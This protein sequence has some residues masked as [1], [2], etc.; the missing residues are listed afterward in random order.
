MQATATVPVG[1]A[2]RVLDDEGDSQVP[3]SEPE[4]YVTRRQLAAMMCLSVRTID[5]MVE[6]GIPSE[7]WGRRTRRFLPSRAIAW[8]REQGRGV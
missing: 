7:A 5:S 3:T 8:A 1:G 2:H 6:G 4:R